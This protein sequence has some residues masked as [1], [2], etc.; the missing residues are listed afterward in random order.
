MH[1]CKCI[2]RDIGYRSCGEIEMLWD[3]DRL[4][5]HLGVDLLGRKV[6]AR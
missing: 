1:Y 6:V 3:W 4:G 5:G 2:G